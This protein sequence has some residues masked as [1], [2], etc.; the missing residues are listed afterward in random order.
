MKKEYEKVRENIKQQGVEQLELFSNR[1]L[2]LCKMKLKD[3]DEKKTINVK[4]TFY[5]N[6]C[7]EIEVGINKVILKKEENKK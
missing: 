5:P 6:F 1:I 3:F 7:W 4:A 2:Q